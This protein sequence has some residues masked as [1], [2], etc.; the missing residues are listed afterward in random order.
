M[1]WPWLAPARQFFQRVFRA[2]L[3]DRIL[4]IGLA[5]T[6]TGFRL[7]GHNGIDGIGGPGV[8]FTRIVARIITRIISGLIANFGIFRCGGHLGR[9]VLACFCRFVRLS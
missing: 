3:L 5:V 1:P 9:L 4:A 8:I 6:I 2:N 7:G